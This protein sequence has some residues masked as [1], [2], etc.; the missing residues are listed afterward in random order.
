MRN[1][2]RGRSAFVVC[3]VVSA[4]LGVVALPARAAGD[5]MWPVSGPV[6]RGFDA[7]GSPFGSGHRGIDIGAAVG[8]VVVAPAPGTVTF[9]GRV[10]G[11][12]YVTIAHGGAV[13]STYSWLSAVLVQAGDVVGRGEPIAR[14]GFAHPGEAAQSS[15]HLGVKVGDVYV[16]PLDYLLPLDLT[17]IIRLAPL[18]AA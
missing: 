3:L 14:S 11:A 5:W 13:S 12:R 8:T 15:L 7:P 1:H 6:L 16:D 10:A 18:A 17:T 9:A 4:H 2:R